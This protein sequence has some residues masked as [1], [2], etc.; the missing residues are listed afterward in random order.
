MRGG[1]RTAGAIVLALG[2]AF[3]FAPIVSVI[4][5]SF[6]QS[7]LVTVWSGF[8]TEWYVTLARDSRVL[9]AV[10]LSLSIA[11][12]AASGAVFI[13][14][15]TAYALARFG[16][17][18]ARGL[19]SGLVGAPLVLPEV[20]T[21]LS[22]LLMFVAME[23]LIGWPEGRGAV[24][25]AIAHI[26]FAVAYATVVVQ[27]RLAGLDPALEEAAADLGARPVRAFLSVVLPLI[28]PALAA[29][30]LLTFALSLDDFVITAFVTGPG[31]T[32][33]PLLVFSSVKLGVSPEIN[34]L[35][36]VIVAVVAAVTLAATLLQRRGRQ[37]GSR[38]AK[39]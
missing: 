1:G 22:L 37:T 2:Y 16:R 8:S 25:I 27:A 35:G 34:A 12:V 38:P 33:L 15:L 20:T 9:D 39:A 23:R 13:G 28:A 18:R 17:F 5:Y 3:L 31:A 21:G 14:T 19:F 29:A 32:T 11:I 7:R 4:V 6:N 24:T 10:R 26:T 30:W 36:T